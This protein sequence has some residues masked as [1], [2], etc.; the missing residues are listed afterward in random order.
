ML[1]GESSG[2][3]LDFGKTGQLV[4]ALKNSYVYSGEYS[5]YRKRHFGNSA[6][7]R[8]TYQF[9]VS[10]Q[11]HD[12]IGNRAFGSRLSQIVSFD[13]LKLAAG[14]MLLS[15]YI[16]LIFM[17]E[18]YGETAPFLYFVSHTDQELVSAVQKGRKDEFKDFQWQGDIPDPQSEQTYNNSKLNWNF[19]D[20]E[21][22]K[23]LFNFYRHLIRIRG[24]YS[25]LMNFD[26]ANLEVSE[27][28]TDKV[29]YM[30][31][32]NRDQSVVGIFNF[33]EEETLV[34]LMLPDRKRKWYKVLDSADA[35]W[36]GKGSE[37]PEKIN[38][39]QQELKIKGHSFLLYESEESI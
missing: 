8:P 29:I 31:R 16:P 10:I 32:W 19:L 5:E 38:G 12:Q 15:P 2:Y 39:K 7:E 24:E 17:G 28:D 23:A 13:A 34:R 35:K 9:V 6:A 11:N 26:R 21:K 1:T 3:Y 27:T 36:M 33:N 37:A 25:A 18:E 20:I 4:D 30:R 14:T 22:H